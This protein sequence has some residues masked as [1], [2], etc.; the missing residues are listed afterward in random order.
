MFTTRMVRRPPN[1]ASSR[2]P[3]N[4][5]GECSGSSSRVSAEVAGSSGLSRAMSPGTAE[6]L[7]SAAWNSRCERPFF[8]LLFFPVFPGTRRKVQASPASA[9]RRT[10]PVFGSTAF[11]APF[12]RTVAERLGRGRPIW[13]DETPM[14]SIGTLP[15]QGSVSCT[16]AAS[17]AGAGPSAGAGAPSERGSIGRP[18]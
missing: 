15:S 8:F 11:H 2:S 6:T 1:S 10:R 17:G 7:P 18:P 4:A 12:P 5:R 13:V 16:G 3:R 9:V 14:R